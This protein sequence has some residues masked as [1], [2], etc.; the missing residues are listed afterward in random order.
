MNKD[1]YRSIGGLFSSGSAAEAAWEGSADIFT[2]VCGDR[3]T[4]V[5]F[6]ASRFIE[7]TIVVVIGVGVFAEGLGKRFGVYG[8]TA[9]EPS[10][11]DSFLEL[12]Q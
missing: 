4:G 7:G 2:E 1:S 3:V 11:L 8:T 5:S 9:L 10:P 12:K 6:E